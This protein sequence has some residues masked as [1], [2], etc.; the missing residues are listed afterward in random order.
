MT[1]KMTE[2]DKEALDQLYKTITTQWSDHMIGKLIFDLQTFLFE[3]D[4]DD[5]SPWDN[6]KL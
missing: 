6:T 5:M 4:L 1:N 3:K 2:L